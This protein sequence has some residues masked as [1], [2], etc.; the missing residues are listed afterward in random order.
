MTSN[1][2]IIR[3]ANVQ[4]V[5]DGNLERIA[6]FFNANYVA[7][8]AGSTNS[9]Y[10]AVRRYTKAIHAAFS[11]LSVDVEILAESDK[12]ISWQRTIHGKQMATFQGFPP[13]GLKISWRD[14]VVSRLE[15]GKIAEDWV[16]TDLAE[17][18][19][20]SVKTAEASHQNLSLMAKLDIQNLDACAKLFANDFVWHYFNPKLPEIEGD[21]R[22]VDGLKGFFAKL[23]KTTSGSFKVNPIDARSAGDE[24]VVTHVCDHMTLEGNTL[25]IDAIVVW[26]IVDGKIT[27][28][29]DI[30]AINTARTPE[31]ESA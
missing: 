6:D 27:E 16:V 18:L 2:S 22:G 7:N 14:M 10:K 29:W 31:Q 4:I 5:E 17:A 30:P 25:E 21:H 24:L 11:E 15:D 23:G 12:H 13:S 3:D 19:L 28:A 26:R 20:R 9:G 8:V 1:A